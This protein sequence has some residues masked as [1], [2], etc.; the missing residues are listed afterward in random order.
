MQLYIIG[1][2]E[3]LLTIQNGGGYDFFLTRAPIWDPKKSNFGMPTYY[4]MLW[5]AAEINDL[6]YLWYP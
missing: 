2:A 4:G 1:A 3:R 5:Y 6:W